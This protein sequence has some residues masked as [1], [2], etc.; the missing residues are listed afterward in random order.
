MLLRVSVPGLAQVSPSEI[1]NPE[2]K[3]AEQT[4]LPQLEKLNRAVGATKFPFKFYLSRYVGLDPK[5]ELETDTRGIEFVRFHDRVVLKI[6]GNYNAAYNRQILTDNQRA[7]R[8]FREVIA[9]ILHLVSQTIPPDV[10]CDAIGF[11]VSHHVR[12]RNKSYDYEGKEILV[13]VLDKPDAFRFSDSL[14]ASKQQT[15]LNRSEVYLNGRDFGLQLGARDA[16]DVEALAR[17]AS[18]SSSR[19]AV[20]ASS[21]SKTDLRLPNLRA[22]VSPSFLRPQDDI[23]D[24]HVDPESQPVRANAGSTP[25]RGEAESSGSPSPLASPAD[26][27]RLQTEYQHQLDELAKAGAAHFHFVDYAAPS[28][29]VFRGRVVLQL[30]LRN[31]MHF[32]S[33]AGSI[34]KRAA[35]TFDLFLAPA[36]KGILDKLPAGAPFQDLDTSVI[37]QLATKSVASSEA[38]EFVCPMKALRQFVESEITNQQLVDESVVL[39]NGVRIA[40]NLQQVE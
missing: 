21:D 22:D 2:L 18:H 10:A 30:T 19:S 32:E 38:V 14:S 26:A 17:P 3:S 34:Y 7:G 4:Y 5:Q 40:L 31:T 25:L 29:A 23:N 9:P 39:V 16:V 24:D 15:I 11:E 28:F 1:V 8:T 12:S 6:T 35:Q 27:D 33:D 37:N 36:L 20:L 13:M